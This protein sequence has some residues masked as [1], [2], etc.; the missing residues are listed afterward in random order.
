MVRLGKVFLGCHTV[1]LLSPVS[2]AF[3]MTQAGLMC[4]SI[5]AKP[6]Q[7]TFLENV[8]PTLDEKLFTIT[9]TASGQGKWNFGYIDETQYTGAVNYVSFG[10]C[11]AR[12]GYWDV[13][14]L[15]ATWQGLGGAFVQSA[16]NC[17]MVGMCAQAIDP[18][19]PVL[20]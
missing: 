11:A 13:G 14:S 19:S 8:L 9:V 15:T 12:S 2:F 17:I 3:N 6:K 4:K 18:P 5:T 20:I 10:D 16:A 7:K 1:M